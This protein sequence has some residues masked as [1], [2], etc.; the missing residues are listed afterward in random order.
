MFYEVREIVPTYETI[1]E[2]GAL[3]RLAFSDVAREFQ[4]TP[5][6]CHSHPSF[7]TDSD[8]L[9]SLRRPGVICFAAYAN[10]APVGFVAIWPKGPDAYELTRLCALPAHRHM[11][12]GE[13]LMQ[14]A[15][16]AA[17]ERGARRIEI[18]IIDASERLKRWYE[19]FGFRETGKHSYA[20]LP[21][22]VCEMQH[23][24]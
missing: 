9:A 7:L 14:A 4:L 23:N 22:V 16:Q 12:L 18:G 20:H 2:I 10:N 3:I 17:K 21:F 15:I 1:P 11:G 13:Q 5:E 8:L 6:N 24:L 19:K